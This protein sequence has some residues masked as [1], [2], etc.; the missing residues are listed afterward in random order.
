[1]ALGYMKAYKCIPPDLFLV[2]S[3]G[4]WHGYIQDMVFTLNYQSWE[5]YFTSLRLF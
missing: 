4:G 5:T 2:R 1:M 3:L